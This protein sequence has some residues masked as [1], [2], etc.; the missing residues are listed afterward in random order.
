MELER[1]WPSFFDGNTAASA[2]PVVLEKTMYNL[3]AN[4]TI[5]LDNPLQLVLLSGQA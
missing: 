4:L 1:T 2:I 3:L 5:L